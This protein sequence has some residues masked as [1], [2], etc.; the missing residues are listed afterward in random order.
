MKPTRVIQDL[1]LNVEVFVG[2]RKAMVLYKAAAPAV[3][4]EIRSIS[5]YPTRSPAVIRLWLSSWTGPSVFRDY[6]RRAG[7]KTMLESG[8]N[9]GADLDRL[10]SSGSFRQGSISLNRKSTKIVGPTLA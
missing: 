5:W 8:R 6:R 7:W 2:G 1:N 4:G 10:Q 3:Q 9:S